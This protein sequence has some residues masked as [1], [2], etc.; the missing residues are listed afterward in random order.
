MIE[1][2]NGENPQ[3]TEGL[4]DNDKL[5]KVKQEALATLDA[6]R[7]DE[8]DELLHVDPR[9][10]RDNPDQAARLKENFL[11][12]K[13]DLIAEIR[14]SGREPN[15]GDMFE[16][17]LKYFG[18]IAVVKLA[19]TSHDEPDESL[20]LKRE[21]EDLMHWFTKNGVET[22]KLSRVESDRWFT[23]D[24]VGKFEDGPDSYRAVIHRARPLVDTGIFVV[25]D[26]GQMEP[27][28]LMIVK[29][30]VFSLPVNLFEEI[31]SSFNAC[32][33]LPGEDGYAW[34]EVQKSML[35]DY[36]YGDRGKP[37]DLQRINTAYISALIPAEARESLLSPEDQDL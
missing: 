2:S 32:G 15:M 8:L 26:G 16:L 13:K 5:A 6:R 30:T 23:V 18:L 25:G 17:S 7:Q 31:M 36:L 11:R 1:Q 37:G 24:I 20:R 21:F 35:E 3:I 28:D 10:A 19:E 22:P 29:E 34:S 27:A 14:E 33:K 12:D 4:P 9:F